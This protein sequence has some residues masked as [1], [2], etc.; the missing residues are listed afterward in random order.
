MFFMSAI[1]VVLSITPLS[2]VKWAVSLKIHMCHKQGVTIG[3]ML[4]F[5]EIEL[6][7]L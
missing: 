4:C 5:Q 3:E 2:V 1:C 6:I 7:T